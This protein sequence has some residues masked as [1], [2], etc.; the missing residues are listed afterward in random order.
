MV[1]LCL[2]HIVTEYKTQGNPE[3]NCASEFFSQTI[4]LYIPLANNGLLETKNPELALLVTMWSEVFFMNN[5]ETGLPS[6]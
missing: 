6:E 2:L 1:P 4:V 3:Q 5:V